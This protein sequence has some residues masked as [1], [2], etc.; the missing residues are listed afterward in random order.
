MKTSTEISNIAAAVVA[1]QAEIKPIIKDSTNPHFK[2]TYASLDTILDTVRP[3]LAKHG[4]S[5]VQGTSYP[6]T[7]EAGRVTAFTVETMLLHKSGEWITSSAV[8]PLQKNDPQGAG[9]AITY[10]RRY[11]LGALLALA[12]EEDDDANVASGH[13]AIPVQRSAPR[14][15]AAAPAPA[16]KPAP[17][18]MSAV[19]DVLESV[20]QEFDAEVVNEPSCPKCSSGMWDNRVGKKNPKA[21]DFKCKNKACDGVIW[22]PKTKRPVAAPTPA[23]TVLDSWSNPE[24]DGLPF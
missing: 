9:G 21:P 23:A 24:D 18:G 12:T 2:N 13:A 15:A 17:A 10:G 14:P 20:V 19:A 16:P 22:P 1:V 3:V 4:L 6:T 7:D 11:S 8:M 5:L